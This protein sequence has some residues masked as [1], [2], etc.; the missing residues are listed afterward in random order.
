MH[1]G[2]S[3][4]PS[5]VGR[6]NPAWNESSEVDMEARFAEAMEMAGKEFVSAVQFVAKSWIPARD[7]VKK[8]MEQRF[9]ADPSGEIMVLKDYTIWRTHLLQLEE[10]MKIAPLIKFVLYQDQGT[11]WRVQAVPEREESFVSRV[12]LYPAWQGVRDDELSKL[13]GIPDCVFVHATGFIGGNKTYAG[14]LQ[15]AKFTLANRPKVPKSTNTK[16]TSENVEILFV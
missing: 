2:F 11:Q 14:A 12:P 9:E 10:E 13:A 6:L 5:R 1:V 15:M 3:D 8:A 4:L 16:P 7:I